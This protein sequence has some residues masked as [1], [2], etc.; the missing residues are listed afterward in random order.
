MHIRRKK[1]G[2][3]D[4]PLSGDVLLFGLHR[5]FGDRKIITR[6]LPRNVEFPADYKAAEALLRQGGAACIFPEDEVGWYGERPPDPGWFA[7]ARR[8]GVPAFI[9]TIEGIYDIYPPFAGKPGRGGITVGFQRSA[10][11]E[12]DFRRV[13]E[14]ERR[15]DIALRTKRIPR[16]ARNVEEILYICPSCGE[17][18]TLRGEISG[19][20]QCK[21]CRNAWTL[22][23]G[24]GLSDNSTGNIIPLGYI[25]DLAVDSLRRLRTR[26][27]RFQVMFL[28]KGAAI[29]G[30]LM[31]SG[32][33]FM[34]ALKQKDG[35]AFVFSYNNVQSAYLEG[36]DRLNVCC[37]QKD[38]EYFFCLRPPL[39]ASLFLL[40][41]LRIRSAGATN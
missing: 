5:S 22:V 26:D 1:P 34:V 19:K 38:R 33:H 35:E 10:D 27:I 29:P 37:L 17:L 23:R 28:Q 7:L 39:H 3:K 18:L 31:V 13:T 36:R 8:T 40:H 9:V 6:S 25:E 41:L 12:T 21:S 30:L 24:K 14:E 2:R 4:I 15:A 20:V 32:D 11:P 16:D